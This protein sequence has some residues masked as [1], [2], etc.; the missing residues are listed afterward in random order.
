MT[1]ISKWFRDKFTRLMGRKPSGEGTADLFKK[2][3][4]PPGE[5]ASSVVN[6]PVSF[7]EE[8][9][10]RW[11]ASGAFAVG[12]AT[13]IGRVREHNEDALLVVY[14]VHE[15]N[16]ALPTFGL[17]MVADGM[18][19]HQSGEIASSLALR[20]AA[21]HLL[22]QIY[23]PLLSGIE[24]GGDQPALTDVVREALALANRTVTRDY[25]G[26]GSTLTCGMILEDRLFLG[27][28][29]DSRAYLLR[30]GQAPR[31]LT[32]DHSLVNRLVEMGQL[33]ADEAANHPQRNV[34]YRAIG[35]GGALEIDVS[36]YAL[37]TGDRLMLCS[38]GLWGFVEEAEIWR[39]IEQ[40]ATPQ[41]ACEQLVAAA[42]A[43]GGNDNIT[44]ILL[45]I[46]HK[47]K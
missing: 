17:F 37:L 13:D 14:G 43:A 12:W 26:S 19:G 11:E 7:V 39:V 8:P 27:H 42:N 15:A 2:A 25:P 47:P 32:K 10:R 41:Q 40:A 5:S 36:T 44:V 16:S 9:R 22:A 45:E 38:D 46:W 33:Q 1:G 4:T 6:L 31:Q 21:N 23:M 34:L 29:G 3:A 20:M 30:I 35:Q 28:V 18:G 24:R